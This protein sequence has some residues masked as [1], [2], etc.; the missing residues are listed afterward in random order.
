MIYKIV[1]LAL[2]LW[3]LVYTV[4]YAYW[5]WKNSNKRGAV[6]IGVLCA[7]TIALGIFFQ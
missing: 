6:G 4:S 7:L 1:I 3:S 2:E 5:E